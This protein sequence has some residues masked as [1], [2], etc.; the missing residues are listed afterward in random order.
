MKPRIAITL[1]DPAGIGPEIVSAAI[2]HPRVLSVCTPV[3]IGDPLAFALHHETLPTVEFL[4]TPGINRRL[5]LGRPSKEAGR[6]AIQALDAGVNC[7][8][9]KQADALVTAPVSKESFA[10]ADHGFPGHTE[11]LAKKSGVSSYGML[12][13]AGELRA[14]LVTRH[15][16][17]ADVSK[18]L[19]PAA[20]E[21]AARLGYD[22]VR[23]ILGKKNPRL[24]LCGLNPH[25]GDNGLIGSEED[26]TLRP[27]LAALKRKKIMIAGPFAADAAFRDMVQGVY[28]LALACYHDQGMIPLKVHAPDRMVNLTLGL[29]YIRTSPAH[30]TA[31]D[32]AGKKRAHAEPMIEAIVLAAKYSGIR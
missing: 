31:Y 13:V 23:R 28:D 30:G 9:N 26:R 20:I 27:T 4:S 10:Q 16:P 11:W 1:G 5:K 6:S 15:I 25:A 14:L 7:M 8:L 19:T 12:M 24:V 3:V 29:P 18:T 17:L 32:I 22:F 2:R 21:I